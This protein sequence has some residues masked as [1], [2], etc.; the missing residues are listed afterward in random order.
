MPHGRQSPEVSKTRRYLKILRP[1]PS[2]FYEMIREG[3]EAQ[4]SDHF[5]TPQMTNTALALTLP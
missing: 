5:V 2:K 4:H 3:Y 1:N